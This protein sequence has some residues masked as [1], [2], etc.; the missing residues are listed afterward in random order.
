MWMWSDTFGRK[1]DMVH[2]VWHTYMRMC[3]WLAETLTAT[4]LETKT[5]SH[6]FRHH[7]VSYQPAVWALPSQSKVSSL[8]ERTLRGGALVLCTLNYWVGLATCS[9][10]SSLP[11]MTQ[12]HTAVQKKQYKQT[13]KTKCYTLQKHMCIAL[14][15]SVYLEW[16]ALPQDRVAWE[17]GKIRGQDM[18]CWQ[19]SQP[20]AWGQ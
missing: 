9:T 15:W 17:T 12:R 7:I 10:I 3:Q 4:I 13:N 18:S 1:V 16:A 20:S 5:H 8:G 14:L 6:K 2:K 19:L 11:A